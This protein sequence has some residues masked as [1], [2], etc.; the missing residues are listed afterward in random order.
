MVIGWIGKT[1]K[2]AINRNQTTCRIGA[3]CYWSKVMDD[4][5]L[6][7]VFAAVNALTVNPM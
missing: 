1:Y 4:Y 6:S 7:N 2:E 3:K 5:E